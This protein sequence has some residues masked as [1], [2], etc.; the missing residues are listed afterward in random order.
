MLNWVYEL[1]S[2]A[3]FAV[4]TASA[5]A[6]AWL[7]VFIFRPLMRRM[8]SGADG[9]Q[10]NAVLD[11][12]LSGTGLVYGLLLGLI[13]AATYSNYAEV[14]NSVSEEATIARVLYR[15]ISAYPEPLRGQLRT[16]MQGYVRHVVDQEWPSQRR[17]RVASGGELVT[18]MDEQLLSFE[19]KTKGQEILHGTTVAQISRFLQARRKRLDSAS[20]GLPGVLW[21]VLV[22]GALVSLAFAA[23]LRRGRTGEPPAMAS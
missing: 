8:F 7:G 19:P 23:M 14:E 12:L 3:V 2:W 18:R 13:A 21:W 16:D 10:R 22:L 6:L 4:F 9:E 20:I 15:D 1:P 11:M 5:V 17:G